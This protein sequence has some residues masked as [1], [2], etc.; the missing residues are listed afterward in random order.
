IHEVLT[1]QSTEEGVTLAGLRHALNVNGFDVKDI[2]LRR[3]GGITPFE[4]AADTFEESKLERLENQ[5]DSANR[6][7]KVLDEALAYRGRALNDLRVVK[8]ENTEAKLKELTEK[9]GAGVP[10]GMVTEEIRDLMREQIEREVTFITEALAKKKE[11]RK[12]LE[13]ER[14]QYD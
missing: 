12:K 11:D 6:R 2:V 9:Y 1:T 7:I 3:W 10:G 13:A 8:G 5:L 14:E 4:A